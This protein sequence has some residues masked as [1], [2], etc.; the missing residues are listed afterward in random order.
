[1][2]GTLH[3]CVTVFISLGADAAFRFLFAFDFATIIWTGNEQTD[4]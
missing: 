2:L 1:M 4:S 3:G